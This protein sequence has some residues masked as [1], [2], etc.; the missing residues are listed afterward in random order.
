M[1]LKEQQG[2][3]WGWR[4][5]LSSWASCSKSSPTAR[6]WYSWLCCSATRQRAEQARYG[7]GRFLAAHHDDKSEI[8]QFLCRALDEHARFRINRLVITI[9]MRHYR[10][11]VHHEHEGAELV[12]RRPESQKEAPQH[13]PQRASTWSCTST[14]SWKTSATSATSSQNLSMQ[15]VR[16]TFWWEE[17]HC[18][19]DWARNTAD[20]GGH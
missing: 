7:T 15:W 16:S 9:L 1:V 8:R 10:Q 18:H 14:T 5:K 20:Q 17:T 19:R 4:V 6:M 11:Q 2:A 12:R 3:F 13:Y